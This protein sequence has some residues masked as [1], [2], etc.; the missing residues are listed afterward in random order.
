MDKLL[1]ILAMGNINVGAI[2]GL[3]GI[4][5]LVKQFD[6]GK[7]L[8]GGFYLIAVLVLGLIIGIFTS[9][10][11]LANIIISGFAHAGIASLVYQYGAKLLPVNKLKSRESDKFV[12]IRKKNVK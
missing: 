10:K 2:I 5:L 12:I 6:V 11:G 9:E 7:R 1:Q 8:A 3:I 4:L